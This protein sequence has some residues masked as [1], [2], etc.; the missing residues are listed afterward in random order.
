MGSA[1][2][3]VD[4]PDLGHGE[5]TLSSLFLMKEDGAALR[6]VQAHRVYA[7][8]QSLVVQFFAYNLEADAGSLVTQT[9]MW[10]AG[11]LIA[12]SKPE[13][14]EKRG[15]GG[16]AAAHTRR[17]NLRPFGPG[18]YEVRIVLTDPNTNATASRRAAF[19]IE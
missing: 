11:E 8:R 16:P 4:I 18:E 14:I 5:L 13:P 10:R 6:P 17:I 2:Q 19:T 7:Q 15:G 12:A 3:W 9:E 1:M